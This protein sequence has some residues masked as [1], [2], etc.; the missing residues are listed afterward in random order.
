MDNASKSILE[1]YDK[2][3]STY[4]TFSKKLSEVISEIIN[5]Q[6]IKIHSITSRIKER[7]SLNEKLERKNNKYTHLF[8]VT[9]IAGIRII[10]Y[11]ADDVDKIA[12]IIKKEFNIDKENS[13]DKRKMEPDRFGYLSLHY[14]V[15][16]KE[17]RCDLPEYKLFSGLKAEIQIRSLLQHGWAEIEHDWGYKQNAIPEDMRR[18]FS[19][20]AGTLELVDKEFMNLRDRITKRREQVKKQINKNSKSI[21]IDETSLSV[22]LETS[23]I[24][25][26]IN[27][28]ILQ[29]TCIND[30]KQKG[31]VNLN[32]NI[33]MLEYCNIK[34]ID[35]LEENLN[36]FQDT[37]CKFIKQS[38]YGKIGYI[39]KT[40]GILMLCYILCT[41]DNKL[42]TI[43][44]LLDV[45]NGSFPIDK[46]DEFASYLLDCYKK[47]K[48]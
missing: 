32:D 3:Y 24:Y 9:D 26:K 19:I 29:M 22:F 6:G 31:N 27:E 36:K 18:E 5:Q 46:R 20:L 1:D 30:F 21:I 28:K 34:Y 25:K 7:N 13:I 40:S 47:I 45:G 41:K 23:E 39:I 15:E 37:I 42:E 11:F 48:D 43:R 38:I 12:E 17:N 8:D 16:L 33:K 10:T 4:S 44:G 14:I 35:K 2:Q